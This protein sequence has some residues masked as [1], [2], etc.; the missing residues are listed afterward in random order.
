M[1]LRELL[2]GPV[3]VTPVGEDGRCVD[4]SYEVT[5]ALD[6]LIAG[7]LSDPIRMPNVPNIDLKV[8][9]EVFNNRLRHL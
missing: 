3:V 6:N 4:W 5:G 7:R 8:P 9:E 2:T 1:V